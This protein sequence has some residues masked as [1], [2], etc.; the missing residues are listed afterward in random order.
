MQQKSRIAFQARADST[1]FRVRVSLDGQ[2]IHD[3]RGSLEPTQLAVEFDD[4]GDAQHQ[5]TICLEGKT[6]A[7]TQVD[8][9]GRIIKDHLVHL[10]DFTVDDVNVDQLIWENAGYYHD[11]NGTSITARHDFFGDMGCNGEVR[12]EFATPVYIWLLEKM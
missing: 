6:P 10:S 2:I 11:V 12:L 9:Q 5:L 4:S 1:D 7:H 3:W 8:D